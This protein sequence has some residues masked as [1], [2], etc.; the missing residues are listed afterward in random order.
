MGL[1]MWY[2]EKGRRNMGDEV[3][4]DRATFE[5]CYRVAMEQKEKAI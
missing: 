3:T 4:V 2:K 5:V 1:W